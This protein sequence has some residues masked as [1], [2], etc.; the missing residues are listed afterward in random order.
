VSARG[1][2]LRII[3]IIPADARQVV[4]PSIHANQTVVIYGEPGS[5]A[6]QYARRNN[7]LFRAVTTAEFVPDP[8]PIEPTEPLGIVDQP[9]T[10]VSLGTIEPPAKN[11][12]PGRTPTAAERVAISPTMSFVIVNGQPTLFE[13]YNI[14]GYNYFKLRDLAAALS[15]TDKQF[16]VG[17]DN[18]SLTVT[19]TSGRAYMP[20]GGELTSSKG[21]HRT[22]NPTPSK[23][24]LDGRELDLMSYNIGGFNFFRLR[25]IMGALG[26]AVTYDEATRNIGINAF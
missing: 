7:I 19:I 25:D 2:T 10:I 23:I 21:T 1:V 14:G 11:E 12:P 26:V 22:A 15:G 3:S 6:E 5:Y 20:I 16:A 17:F 4:I 18:A 24:L 13:A 9:A 8:Y